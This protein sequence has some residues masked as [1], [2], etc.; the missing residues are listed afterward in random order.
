MYKRQDIE[1]V[2]ERVSESERV[3]GGKWGETNVNQLE[4]EYEES[5]Q[6]VKFSRDVVVG[7]LLYTSNLQL[8][9]VCKTLF[10]SV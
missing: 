9:A 8:R 7:C 4:R 5:V 1:T 10:D 3:M 2:S 6:R